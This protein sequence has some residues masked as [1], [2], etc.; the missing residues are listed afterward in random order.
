MRKLSASYRG[1]VPYFRWTREEIIQMIKERV[2]LKLPLSDRR[3]QEDN[4]ALYGAARRMFGTWFKACQRAKINL[5]LLNRRPQWSKRKIRTA[6]HAWH[7]QNPHSA[8]RNSKAANRRIHLW[9][10]AQQYFPDLNTVRKE[11]G[12]PPQRRWSQTKVIKSL[13]ARLRHG[14]QINSKT[15]LK[16]DRFLYEATRRWFGSYRAAVKAAGFDFKAI[17]SPIRGWYY[18]KKKYTK[19]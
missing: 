13:R 17:R 10:V 14:Q 7:Q 16:Q 1:H 3:V 4:H 9:R 8:P 12:L 5:S 19:V 11:L 2:R 6:L 18:T 15:L